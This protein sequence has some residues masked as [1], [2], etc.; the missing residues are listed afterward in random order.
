MPGKPVVNDCKL[1]IGDNSLMSPLY[2]NPLRLF[3]GNHLLAAIGNALEFPL[4]KI[5]NIY[6]ISQNRVDGC[7][8]PGSYLFAAAGV[9]NKTLAPLLR[10]VRRGSY[11]MQGVQ[12]LCDSA[13]GGSVSLRRPLWPPPQPLYNERVWQLPLPDPYI[14]C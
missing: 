5:S 1:F 10:F 7:D 3:V 9:T 11:N 13:G 6:L 4:D 14:C 12:F 8:G 2:H